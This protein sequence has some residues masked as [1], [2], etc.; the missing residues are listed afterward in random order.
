MTRSALATAGTVNFT[1]LPPY[2]CVKL[3]MLWWKQLVKVYELVKG[4]SG[5]AQQAGGLGLVPA[6]F[7]QGLK[8]VRW[9]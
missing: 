9:L 4:W 7:N 8:N 5:D 1:L 6:S 2:S 3:Q